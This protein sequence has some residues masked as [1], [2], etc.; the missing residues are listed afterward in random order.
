MVAYYR[1]KIK[2]KDGI[3]EE[4]TWLQQWKEQHQEEVI[5]LRKRLMKEN[6]HTSKEG[7]ERLVDAELLPPVWEGPEAY[8]DGSNLLYYGNI[9][10]FQEMYLDEVVDEMEDVPVDEDIPQ[11]LEI[12]IPDDKYAK[13][14]EILDNLR[15]GEVVKMKF[16]LQ[17]YDRPMSDQE[18]TNKTGLSR[19]GAYKVVYWAL[20][21]IRKAL[22]ED[23]KD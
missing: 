14:Y 2:T 10:S 9:E 3:V 15:Y 22:Q 12:D 7:I 5:E 17:G 21:L 6:V 13:L 16:G 1:E 23:K 18:I 4:A 19:S 20:K 11:T 8:K